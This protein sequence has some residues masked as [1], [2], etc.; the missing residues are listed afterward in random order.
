[1]KMPGLFERAIDSE[2]YKGG[3]SVDTRLYIAGRFTEGVKKE[4]IEWVLSALALFERC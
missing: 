2:T 4:S 3:V 1:M